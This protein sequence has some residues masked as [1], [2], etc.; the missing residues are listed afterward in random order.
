M[1]TT[2]DYRAIG[3]LIDTSFGR[4]STVNNSGTSIKASLLGE[5]RLELSYATIVS[6]PRDTDPTIVLPRFENEAM[7]LIKG[8]IKDLKKEFKNLRGVTLK[9]KELLNQPYLEYINYNHFNQLRKAYY[10]R[11]VILEIKV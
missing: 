4:S 5:G 1:L 3:Q 9:T 6:L 8:Y 2:E 10:R 7:Q 11:K